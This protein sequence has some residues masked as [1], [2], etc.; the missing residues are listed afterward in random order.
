MEVISVLFYF[1]LIYLKIFLK[2]GI[3]V[4]GSVRDSTKTGRSRQVKCLPVC[5]SLS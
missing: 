4:P 3:K 2:L 1:C 5:P